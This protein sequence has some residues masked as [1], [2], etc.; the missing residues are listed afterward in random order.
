MIIALLP[1]LL[2]RRAKKNLTQLKRTQ[3]IQISRNVMSNVTEM[4]SF[5]SLFVFL[6]HRAICFMELRI[7]MEEAGFGC[8]RD[9]IGSI[10]CEV[11]HMLMSGGR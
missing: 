3:E 6:S 4:Q 8:A 1:Y 9:G 11:G 2:R 7:G 5:V 10:I